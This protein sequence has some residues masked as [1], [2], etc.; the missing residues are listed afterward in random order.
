MRKEQEKQAE[1]DN[2]MN[3]W[4]LLNLKITYRTNKLKQSPKAITRK[5]TP[6]AFDERIQQ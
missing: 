6:S 2:E 1:Q 4:D 5:T 3:K